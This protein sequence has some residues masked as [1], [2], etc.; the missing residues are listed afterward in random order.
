M[1]DILNKMKE[2][3]NVKKK[4]GVLKGPYQASFTGSVVIVADLNADI[5]EDDIIIRKLPNGNDDCYYVT[6]VTCYPQKIGSFPPHY[7]V[8]FTKT[9]ISPIEKNIQNINFHGSSNVQIGDH[10]TQNIINVFNDLIQKI[11]ASS[12]SEEEKTKVK[13]LLGE[14][15]KHP[16]VTSIVGAAVSSGISLL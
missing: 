10:N 12:A 7:Q 9:P 11:E 15:L 8:K 16:L 3:I 5:A 14:F 6:E 4:D 1:L 13:S 2:S